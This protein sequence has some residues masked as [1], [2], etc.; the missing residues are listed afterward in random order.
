LKRAAPDPSAVEGASKPPLPGFVEPILA[1]LR[2]D[3][4]AR[5]ITREMTMAAI[6]SERPHS[7]VK[8]THPDRLYWPDVGVTKEGLAHYYAGVWRFIAP[9]IVGRPLALVRC[10]DTD[11]NAEA[12]EARAWLKALPR[13]KIRGK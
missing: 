13:G 9:F 8:L 1:T 6:V 3:K 5:E 4:P 11:S 12:A 10:P 7:N 2:E